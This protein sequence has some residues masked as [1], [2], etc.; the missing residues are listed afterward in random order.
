MRDNF[1]DWKV[2]VQIDEPME[3]FLV[4]DLFDPWAVHSSCY[5]EGFSKYDVFGSFYSDMQKFTVAIGNHEKLM[6]FCMAV[7]DHA[8][9]LSVAPSC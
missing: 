5:C 3:G 9:K 1:Y 7:R 8:A 6:A 2:S 4:G